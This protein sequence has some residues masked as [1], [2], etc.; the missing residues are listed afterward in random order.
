[1]LARCDQ[2]CG[3][4]AANGWSLEPV[5]LSADI[6]TDEVIPYFNCTV[7]AWFLR[8]PSLAIGTDGLPRVAYRAE[9]ISGS[10]SPVDPDHPAC[11]TGA[12]VTLTR[13]AQLDAYK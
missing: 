10:S 13:F 1:M 4:G 9:D 8:E 11:N 5:E 6:P 2:S 7:S 12:N 3:Q